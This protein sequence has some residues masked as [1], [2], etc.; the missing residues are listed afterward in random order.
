MSNEII[1]I[2][3]KKYYWDYITDCLI[4]LDD[5]IIEINDNSTEYLNR[6]DESFLESTTNNKNNKNI[7]LIED[8]WYSN[9]YDID[10]WEEMLGRNLN[11]KEKKMFHGIWNENKLNTDIK[12]LQKNIIKYNCYIKSITDNIGNCLFESLASLGLGDNDLGINTHE[13]LRK[14]IGSVL[15][16]A[17]TEIN[18]FPLINLTP[19]EI[20]INGNEIEF[21]EE[22]ITGDVYEY[23]YD[24]MILDLSSNFSWERLPTEFIFMGISR[25]YEVEILIYHN[26]T[27]YIHKINV[28]DNSNPNIE[29]IRLGLINEEHYFPL[30]ELP[31]ELANEPSV[32]DEILNTEIK[33]TKSLN[34]FKKWAK[35][36]MD[37]IDATNNHLEIYSSNECKSNE[38]ETSELV[39]TNES[40][41]LKIMITN[42]KL[43]NELMEDYKQ[44]SNFDDFDI[45]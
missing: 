12:M 26:K 45:I 24:M 14:N 8:E 32:I 15:L 2:E 34:K 31:E 23:D 3:D 5:K 27:N 11:Y 40:N 33:Y 10:F 6:S 28:W 43:T 17:K 29:I 42:K 16:L 19:E 1:I 37:S 36:M 21:I 41:K 25:I 35:L 38:C 13:M 44:I 9:I 4:Q 22:K 20:F 7:Q 39:E 30:L 18:F